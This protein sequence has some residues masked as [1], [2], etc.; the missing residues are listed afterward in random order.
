MSQDPDKDCVVV[1][2]EHGP[3]SLTR[4]ANLPPIWL[5]RM[6][7]AARTTAT[8]RSALELGVF[9]RLADE[10]RG[11]DVGSVAAGIGCPVRST[12][13]LL[14]AL[15]SLD[16]L[17]TDDAQHYRLTPTAAQFLVPNRWGYVGD[18]ASIVINPTMW[19]ALGRLTDA[20]RNDGTVLPQH[21]E[22]PGNPFW[23]TFARSSCLVASPVGVMIA[24]SLSEWM[25]QKSELRV[26]DLGA[27]SG[28][29]GYEILRRVKHAKLTVLDWPN[30]IPEAKRWAD[31]LGIDR[32]RIRF[33]AGDL[34]DVDYGGTYDLVLVGHV[35][36]HFDRQKCA[37]VT[38]RIAAALAPGGRTV[39]HEF[40]GDLARVGPMFGITMLAWTPDGGA[41]TTEDYRRWFSEAGLKLSGTIQN[42]GLPTALLLAEKPGAVVQPEAQ[43]QPVP[44]AEP[45]APPAQPAFATFRW[46]S[47]TGWPGRR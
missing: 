7:E 37:A 8:L 46:Y 44:R 47:P 36:H 27:G 18:Y 12:R 2:P 11:N 38:H 34:L 10:S 5:M 45:A 20:I 9:A 21:A 16:L 19:N 3:D 26:L 28:I 25:A 17:E 33:I 4:G 40:L 30:V 41:Y 29:T 24:E 6:F 14:D 13:V 15:V 31:R 23:E 43:P 35:Y 22:T 39:L 42:V 32:N 1:D